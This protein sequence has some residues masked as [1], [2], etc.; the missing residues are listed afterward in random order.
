MQQLAEPPDLVSPVCLAAAVAAAMVADMG[1]VL[2]W[3]WEV[4]AAVTAAVLA[5]ASNG[6]GACKDAKLLLLVLLLVATAVVCSLAGRLWAL[7]CTGVVW[8]LVDAAVAGAA[9]A[10]GSLVVHEEVEVDEVEEGSCG[11]SARG[12]S[13]SQGRSCC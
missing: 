11:R 1:D 10:A 3:L 2:L 12:G 9:V 6:A 7:A 5:A 13:W 8:R 4:V